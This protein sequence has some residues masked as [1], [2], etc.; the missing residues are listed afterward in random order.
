MTRSHDPID[1]GNDPAGKIGNV[2]LGGK[3]EERSCEV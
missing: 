1:P 2:A 3:E